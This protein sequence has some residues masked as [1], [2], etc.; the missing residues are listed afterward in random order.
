M[1]PLRIPHFLRPPW[2]KGDRH[3]SDNRRPHGRLP[4]S[5]RDDGTVHERAAAL[6]RALLAMVRGMGRGGREVGGPW[7][8][9]IL[10]RELGEGLEPGEIRPY[11]PPDDVRRVDWRVTA[12]LGEVYFRESV[13]ERELPVVLALLRSPGLL[14]GRGGVKGVRAAEIT[15]FLAA[16][17]TA[18][19]LRMGLLV[20]GAR[21]QPGRFCLRRGTR[22]LL[23][24]LET[25]LEE[26]AAW[27]PPLGPE[28]DSPP[29]LDCFRRGVR[30]RSR[31]FLVADMLVGREAPRGWAREVG[32]LAR[33]HR[34]T[35]IRVGDSLEGRLPSGTRTI[36]WDPS[37]ER[38]QVV[39]GLWGG[40]GSWEEK[41]RFEGGTLGLLRDDL[42]REAAK[43]AGELRRWGV[44]VWDLDVQRP[45]LDQLLPRLCGGPPAADP[46][47]WSRGGRRR[48][49]AG[50]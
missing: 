22:Q 2:P 18:E 41:R 38:V 9:V 49:R 26:T 50:S 33:R 25:L 20:V 37:Q 17:A 30:E 4:I 10:S 7:P 24:V 42:L 36:F 43:V 46:A 19:R 23:R 6:A 39:G 48:H 34:L 29:L 16:L 28:P 15:A 31:L 40:G 13:A 35:V 12:R 44:E 8:G 1:R 21:E 45:L 27:G 11:A 32:M 3:R 5:A 47:G 14:G